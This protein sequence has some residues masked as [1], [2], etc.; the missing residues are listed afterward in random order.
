MHEFVTAEDFNKPTAAFESLSESGL[1]NLTPFVSATFLEKLRLE[2]LA[3]YDAYR[4]RRDF[5]SATETTGGATPR[6]M[7][8][9]NKRNLDLHSRG[10]IATV[11]RRSTWCV[12]CGCVTHIRNATVL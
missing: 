4:Q 10:S 7:Y 8:T 1:T 12:W 3:S 11:R 6:N 5:V 2:V 9:V